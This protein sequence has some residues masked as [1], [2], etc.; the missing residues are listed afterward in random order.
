M[1]T[2]PDS[3]ANERCRTR[4]R[5]SAPRTFVDPGSPPGSVVG[6]E[7]RGWERGLLVPLSADTLVFTIVRG[8]C[9]YVSSHPPPQAAVRDANA[10]EDAMTCSRHPHAHPHDPRRRDDG[11][12]LWERWFVKHVIVA[13]F[14]ALCWL[15]FRT[16]TKPSRVTYP[17]QQAA[18]STASLAFGAPLVVAL[19][20]ARRRAVA[21]LRS[22]FALAALLLG[23]TVFIGAHAYLTQ[24]EPYNGP[25]LD[26]PQDYRAQLYHVTQCPEDPTG[27][28]FVGLDNLLA[29][30][31]RE[32]VK[33]YR[34][35]M[36]TALSGPDGILGSD[37][38]ILIKINYQWADRGGTNTDL[39]R[40]LIR[41]IV[42]HP[43]GFTGEIV[44]CENAQFA[45]TSGFDRATNNAQDH[46]LSPHDVVV[47]FQG[48]GYNIS[49]FDWTPI[50]MTQVT[51]YADGNYTDG[52]I[53]MD[54]DAEV[55]GRPSYPKFRTPSGTY[56]SLKNGIWDPES[57]SYSRDRLRFI[58]VPVLKSHHAVYGATASVKHYM[59]VVTRELSTNSHAGIRYGIL[60]AVL[61]EIQLADLNILDAIWINADP[62]T[63]PG[64]TYAGATR[65]DEL[66]ASLDPVALDRW[67][68]KNILI[69]GFLDN[70]FTPPWPTPSADPDDPASAF[71]VYLDNSMYQMLQAG[72]TVTNDPAQI[73][74]RE[75]RGDAGDFDRDG[76]V[77]ETDHAQFAG[78]FTGDGGGPLTPDCALG[79]F[80]LDDDVD[81]EDWSFFRTVWTAAGDP[82]VLPDCS[83]SDLPGDVP[84]DR[85]SLHPAR[86]N[87]TAGGTTIAYALP[88]AGH[89]RLGVFDVSGRTVRSLLDADVEGGEHAVFWDGRNDQGEPVVRGVYSYLL[90]TASSRASGKVVL[91]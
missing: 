46:G 64:T 57:S 89:V 76:D 85:A 12:R 37:D 28:R 73:D 16:G 86:P 5:D 11:T 26:P 4:E 77:D 47:W 38:V 29:V 14:L 10:K 30:M 32:G 35:A 74:V 23:V 19:L 25:V 49:H 90:E 20:L 21:W 6:F 18:I 80:D 81:C 53:V 79:D 69:E 15:L 31:G 63:G 45:S 2:G 70:G 67:A 55:S 66:V 3:C 41:R 1:R 17:C 54:Y 40:G 34:T 60:G 75:G 83:T 22:P 91:R 7:R 52:Y 65:R 9:W 13:G 68:V 48:L 78:C 88:T 50:R 62:Y 59:G 71:R 84:T 43:D 39:L 36:E 82:P 24:A 42:D 44:V 56:I 87:P 33:I 8:N 72:Y 27:D 61:G 58:N 51:E